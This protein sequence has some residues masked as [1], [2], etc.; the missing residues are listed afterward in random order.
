MP[1]HAAARLVEHEIA[2][3]LVAGDEARLL[4]ERRAGRR[5]DAAD[6]DVADLALGVAGD[7][8]DDLGAAH[9]KTP[10][11]IPGVLSGR[12][13]PQERSART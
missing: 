5:R 11:T 8:V 12:A 1:E 4:P 7:D 9:V 2:Q 6:D 10:L 13:F 3:G